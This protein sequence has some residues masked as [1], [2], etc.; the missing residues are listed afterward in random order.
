MTF[1]RPLLA[2]L[3]LL[4][5]ISVASAQAVVMTA[6]QRLNLCKSELDSAERRLRDLRG[7]E[8]LLSATVA[9]LGGL[10]RSEEKGAPF[11]PPGEIGPD[12]VTPEFRA[13]QGVAKKKHQELGDRLAGASAVVG[14]LRRKCEDLELELALGSPKPP[15]DPAL[16]RIFRD[17]SSATRR[18]NRALTDAERKAAEV[19]QKLAE[20]ERRFGITLTAPWPRPRIEVA[21]YLGWPV[22]LN[23]PNLDPF[24]QALQR[25]A[26]LNGGIQV[27]AGIPLGAGSPFDL[28][29]GGTAFFSGSG[30][31]RILNLLGPGSLAV[32]G[33]YDSKLLL[34]TIGLGYLFDRWYAAVDGGLGAGF[35]SLLIRNAATG[36]TIVDND[37]TVRAWMLRGSLAYAL[38]DEFRLGLF[39]A[40]LATQSMNAQVIGGA[41]FTMGGLRNVVV[42]VTLAYAFAAR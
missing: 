34:A 17:L 42:G 38:T 9:F 27:N 22:S 24:N 6:A 31:Q 16:R 35:N 21:A 28:R 41:P 10:I 33:H 7:E 36:A 15:T 2:A 25:G 23:Q 29:F 14:F 13:A 39:L 32:T 3:T 12:P 5:G 40:Y 8:H 37:A 11:H 19:K 26:R 4:V 20:I 18:A 1:S 30:A